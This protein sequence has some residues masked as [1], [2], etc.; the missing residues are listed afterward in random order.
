MFSIM[1]AQFVYCSSFTACIFVCVRG[2]S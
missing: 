1:I 2:L